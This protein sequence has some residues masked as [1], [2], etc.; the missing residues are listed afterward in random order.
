MSVVQMG[1]QENECDYPDNESHPKS[2]SNH[3]RINRLFIGKTPVRTKAN[4]N[5]LTALPAAMRC[6]LKAERYTRRGGKE[7]NYIP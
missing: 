5:R 4:F 2:Y 7:K 6:I 3:N 1:E